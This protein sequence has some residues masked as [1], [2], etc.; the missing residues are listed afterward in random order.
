MLNDDD[1]E[2]EDEDDITGK[3]FAGSRS[4]KIDGLVSLLISSLALVGGCYRTFLAC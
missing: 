4:L 1:D 2:D 3:V